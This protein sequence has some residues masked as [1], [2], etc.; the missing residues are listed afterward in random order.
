[1]KSI[2]SKKQ[3]AEKAGYF[4]IAQTWADEKYHYYRLWSARWQCA[5]WVALVAVLSLSI[6]IMVMM[7]LK[8]WEPIVVQKNVQTGEVFVKPADVANMVKDKPQVESDLVRYVIARETYSSTDEGPR[9]RHV[10]FSSSPAVFKSYQEEHKL[11]NED[12]FDSRLG[13]SGV[14]LVSVEDVIFLD[15]TDPRKIPSKRAARRLQV[16]PI[17]RVDF[18]T[19]ESDG[20]I[21]KTNHWVA[22]LKFDYVGTPNT[23]EAAWANWDGFTVT[24]YRVDQ[25]NV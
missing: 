2:Q 22:T 23:K 15:P 11:N 10:Q 8:S 7:P 13:E 3:S 6:A 5:F 12:S 4:D 24:S 9:Y 21:V 14:R 20:G 17:A 25:R 18:T 19:T 1:M 16:P